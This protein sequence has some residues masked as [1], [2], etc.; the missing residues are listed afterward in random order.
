VNSNLA[1]PHL[2]GLVGRTLWLEQLKAGAI[3][4][5]WSVLGTVVIAK[6]VGWLTNGLRVN[7][8][9]ESTGLDVTEHGEEGYTFE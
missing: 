5:V 8:E 3:V 9:S 2:A 1:A 4:I 6:V 7:E